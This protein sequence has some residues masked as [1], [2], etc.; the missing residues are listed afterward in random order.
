[1]PA[2]RL[3]VIVTDHVA[4]RTDVVPTHSAEDGEGAHDK[5]CK[6]GDEVIGDDDA[7]TDGTFA[8]EQVDGGDYGPED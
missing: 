1:M 2:V 6:P 8:G 5:Y 3:R 7:G 4:P